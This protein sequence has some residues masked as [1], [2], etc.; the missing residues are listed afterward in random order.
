MSKRR[1]LNILYEDRIFKY[2]HL[3]ITHR[4]IAHRQIFT[5]SHNTSSNNHIFTNIVKF[6]FFKYICNYACNVPS[7]TLYAC[8][9][10]PITIF[11]Y[12]GYQRYVT[13]FVNTIFKY[14]IVK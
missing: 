12:F 8:G 5:S 2:S 3:R 13:D 9:T 14:N 1:T 6:H 11:I 4:Q 7:L 10:K